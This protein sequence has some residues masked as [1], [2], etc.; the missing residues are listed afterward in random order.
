MT[1]CDKREIIDRDRLACGGHSYG[2]FST[3]NAMVNTNF[4]KAGIA[5]D[6]CYNRTLTPMTFQTEKRNFWDAPDTYLEMSPLLHADK[7]SGAL[8]MYHGM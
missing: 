8:L 7:M 4:F 3:A 5:G 1:N 2:A 6:G